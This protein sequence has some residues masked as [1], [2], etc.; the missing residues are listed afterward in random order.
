MEAAVINPIRQIQETTS[1]IRLLTLMKTFWGPASRQEEELL[2]HKRQ[3]R[4]HGSSISDI[5]VLIHVNMIKYEPL[6]YNT[7]IYVPIRTT[8]SAF[9]SLMFACHQHCSSSK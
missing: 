2:L 9:G 7:F 5:Y 6:W 3:I 1:G 8:S 4:Y